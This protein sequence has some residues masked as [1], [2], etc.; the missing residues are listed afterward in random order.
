LQTEYSPIAALNR[1]YALSKLS[2]KS[3]AI[4][5]AEKLQLKNSPYYFALLGELYANI[6]DKKSIDHFQTAY[7]L[8][9]NEAE[10]N[11]LKRKIKRLNQ[12]SNKL[13]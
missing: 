12:Q 11:L 5:E 10:K 8:A 9:K 1:T 6:D 4:Q 3:K 7:S 2:G 13:D